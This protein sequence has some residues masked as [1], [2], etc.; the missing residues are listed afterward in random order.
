MYMHVQMCRYISHAEVQSQ[1]VVLVTALHCVVNVSYCSPTN[2]CLLPAACE[3]RLLA[4]G[5]P[6]VPVES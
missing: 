2:Q 4:V 1:P 5:P 3:P 6:Q